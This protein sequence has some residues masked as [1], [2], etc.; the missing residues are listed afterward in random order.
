M[1]NIFFFVQKE[2]ISPIYICKKG[3]SDF[4]ER[5]YDLRSPPT[6]FGG[7]HPPF[8][9]GHRLPPHHCPPFSTVQKKSRNPKIP[10]AKLYL[11]TISCL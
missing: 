5:G 2:N 6:I 4:R 3:N 9:F 7:Q 1:I 10:G 11:K 8:S